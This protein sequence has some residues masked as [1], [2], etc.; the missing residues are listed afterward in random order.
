LAIQAGRFMDVIEI[1][2]ASHNSVE[3]IRDLTEKVKYSP[4]Q[5]RCKVYILDEAHMLST[6]AN[7]ALLKTLEEPPSFVYFILATTE[8]HKF[9]PTIMSRCQ[10]FDFRAIPP[11][12]IAEALRHIAE[13]EG[14]QIAEAAVWTIAEAAGGAM[15]DAESIFDQVVAYAEGAID[16]ATVAAVLGLTQHELLERSAT[17]LGAGDL[18]GL[19]G[20]VDELIA[21]GKDLGQYLKDLTG[22]CG[23]LLRLELGAAAPAWAAGSSEAGQAARALAASVGRR[24]LLGII[25]VLTAASER[26]REGGAEVLTVELALAQAA[27]A[28]SRQSTVDRGREAAAV[29]GTAGVSPAAQAAAPLAVATGETPVVPAARPAAPAP[30]ERVRPAA[31]PMPVEGALTLEVVQE[32]WRNILQEQLKRMRHSATSAIVLEGFPIGLDGTEIH[33]VFP[34]T[35]EFHYRNAC[36]KHKPVIEEALSAILGQA[37]TIVCTQGEIPA[38]RGGTGV[39]PVQTD[40][41]A[42]P[43]E[44]PAPLS[45]EG[46]SSPGAPAPPDTGETPA[47]PAEDAPPAARPHEDAVS[48]AVRRT[49]E[50]FEGSQELPER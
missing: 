50:L 49:L 32:R 13:R 22:F 5:G 25:Q 20:L 17:L 24:R 3:D 41:P 19:F 44:T 38:A 29:A 48:D 31:T 37:I 39:S 16:R 15:R 21:A 36:G 1:D 8:A 14:V 28:D 27:E 11:V 7:N 43:P 12:A 34:A 2:V 6:S 23:D 45:R 30:A 40:A 26:L 46:R 42:P 47:P 35:H 4:A 10:R 33:L 9:L 18:A